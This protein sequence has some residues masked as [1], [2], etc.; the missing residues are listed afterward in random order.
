[1]KFKEIGYDYNSGFKTHILSWNAARRAKFLTQIMNW[2]DASSKQP[3]KIP[4]LY[5]SELPVTIDALLGMNPQK[6]VTGDQL[7]E[8]GL[9]AELRAGKTPEQI[10]RTVPAQIIANFRSDYDDAHTSLLSSLADAKVRRAPAATLLSLQHDLAADESMIQKMNLSERIL[11]RVIRA[12]LNLPATTGDSSSP[13]VASGKT[14][15]LGEPLGHLLRLGD[16]L[17]SWVGSLLFRRYL[18]QP[19]VRPVDLVRASLDSDPG[20]NFDV[21]GYYPGDMANTCSYSDGQADTS[22]DAASAPQT[23]P[24]R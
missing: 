16:G 13:E 20:A 21:V 12:K 17:K 11:E 15:G 2:N 18:S 5:C 1:M 8:A 10:A 7:L 3:P 14:G 6:L 9:N 24:A 22:A 19:I 4:D 23:A